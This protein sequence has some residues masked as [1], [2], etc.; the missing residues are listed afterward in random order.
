MTGHFLFFNLNQCFNREY[1]LEFIY[2]WNSQDFLIFRTLRKQASSKNST[3]YRNCT[4]IYNLI[5]TLTV[6]FHLI[7]NKTWC[8]V[9]HCVYIRLQR[10]IISGQTYFMKKKLAQIRIPGHFLFSDLNQQCATKVS[11]FTSIGR[12]LLAMKQSF[13]VKL[14]QY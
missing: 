2:P 4:K 14:E 3:V 13:P 8:I 7:W 12:I 1:C 11:I 10:S 9:C 5:H 6:I